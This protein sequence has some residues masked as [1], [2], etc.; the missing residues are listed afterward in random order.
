MR[1]LY[2]Q[3]SE[4]KPTSQ[5]STQNSIDCNAYN[6]CRQER[7]AG[8]SERADWQAEWQPGVMA[9]SPALIPL[10][11]NNSQFQ[12][13]SNANACI[14]TK[15]MAVGFHLP[16]SLFGFLSNQIP[17]YYLFTIIPKDYSNKFLCLC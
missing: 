8:S 13:I 12:F 5:R 10:V 7:L 16:L 15:Y 1:T 11:G 9:D 17:I 14:Y 4:T 3:Q 2:S 6:A